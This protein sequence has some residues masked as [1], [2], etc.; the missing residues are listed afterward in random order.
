MSL[1]YFTSVYQKSYLYLV[2]FLNECSSSNW[3]LRS[4]RSLGKMGLSWTSMDKTGVRAH[5]L[6]TT[7]CIQG[8]LPLLKPSRNSLNTLPLPSVYSS[9]QSFSHLR[10]IP[11]ILSAEH[12]LAHARFGGSTSPSTAIILQIRQLFSQWKHGCWWHDCNSREANKTILINKLRFFAGQVQIAGRMSARLHDRAAS[13]YKKMLRTYGADITEYV[14]L[15]IYSTHFSPCEHSP[16]RGRSHRNGLHL[17][18]VPGDIFGTWC[19][20]PCGWQVVYF[21]RTTTGANESA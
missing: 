8:C 15:A 19:G 14:Y 17:P 20:V 10:I 11:N 9:N 16:G 13:P 5:K 6:Y 18:K 1:W 12:P 2:L 7:S 3:L 21:R 4:V